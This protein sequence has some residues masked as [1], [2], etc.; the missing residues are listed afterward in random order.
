MVSSVL[1]IF[2]LASLIPLFAVILDE[3][4]ISKSKYLSA[5]YD[6][7][8]FTSTRDFIIFMGVAIFVIILV[9]NVLYLLIKYARAKYAY[10]IY[11][12]FSA[13]AQRHLYAQ[14]YLA[15]KSGNP[16]KLVRDIQEA[17]LRFSSLYIL[18]LL[19][20]LNE[21]A[22]MLLIL[23][24][25]LIYDP[26]MV[27]LLAAVLLPGFL[28]FYN[29]A[30]R[31]MESLSKVNHGIK[32]DILENLYQSIY[33]FVDVVL[34]NRRKWMFGQYH[35]SADKLAHTQTWLNVFMDAPSRV[36]EMTMMAGVISILFYGVFVLKDPKQLT[37]IIAVFGMAAY[38][39]LP[40]INRS[41]AALLQLKGNEFTLKIIE[42]LKDLHYEVDEDQAPLPFEHSIEVNN[43]HYQY[44]GRDEQVLSAVNFSIK[45]GEKFGIIGKSGS[46][47]TTL[48]NI[49]LGLLPPTQGSIEVDGTPIEADNLPGWHHI[50]GYV[51][52]E[53]Y[54]I[55]GSLADNIA[56]GQEKI[57]MDRLMEVIEMASLKELV[58]SLPK[59][60]HTQVG[61]RGSQ[62][63]GGQRQRVGIARA[64]YAGAQILVFDE[65]TSALDQQTEQEITDSIGNLAENDITMIM[66]AHRIS[67]L[68]Y[69]DRILEF[70][71]GELIKEW[72]YQDLMVK[73]V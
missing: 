34:T 42:P 45:R 25:I 9:K 18:Q 38:R 35:K 29:M 68:K 60:I 46:G 14:G 44:P 17:P 72:Q 65:A 32:G 20:L 28:I 41:L 40:S 3:E 48:A 27:L 2:S 22:V 51:Q 66:I 1:E 13:Q 43:V 23:T 7:L 33:G 37:M 53:N 24:A 26:V 21:G 12:Y 19:M 71:Q 58:D 16:N 55:N 57:D 47:K 39:I 73:Y 54:L 31:K 36:I 62:V 59:G 8:G 70:D 61:D 5:V 6:Y 50:V 63:S 11:K 64:L 69:C 52:Q 10:S 15:L 49:L 56:F 67:T 4:Q 30:K